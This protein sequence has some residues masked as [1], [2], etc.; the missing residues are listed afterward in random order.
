MWAL[1]AECFSRE[2]AQSVSIYNIILYCKLGWIGDVRRQCKITP[3]AFWNI[4]ILWIFL[5]H[6]LAIIVGVDAVV[7]AVVAIIYKTKMYEFNHWAI[8]HSRSIH[9]CWNSIRQKYSHSCPLPIDKANAPREYT[10]Y[11]IQ[12]I[13][14]LHSPLLYWSKRTQNGMAWRWKWLDERC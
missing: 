14:Y 9:K 11:S 7:A 1:S 8:R 10:L 13:C 12:D 3:F 2:R 5:R 4:Y 6:P